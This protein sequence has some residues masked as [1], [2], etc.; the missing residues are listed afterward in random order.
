MNGGV[1]CLYKGKR[2]LF[3]PFILL[4]ISDAKEYNIL[5]C[6]Y[7]S[8]G[9]RNVKCALKGFK[10]TFEELASTCPTYEQITL[11]D[12]ARA[13]HDPDFAKSISQHLVW[14]AMNN[15]PLAN[16]SQGIAGSTPYD[17]LH[18]NG[19]GNLK[20]GLEVVHD[21][22]GVNNTRASEKEKL[23]LLFIAV[24][25]DAKRNSERRVPKWATQ[26][27]VCDLTRITATER[28]ENYFIMNISLPTCRG[29]E[30]MQP[31]LEEWGIV[32]EDLCDTM[33]LLLAYDAWVTCKKLKRWELDNAEAAVTFLME[34]MLRNL[35]R[36][37]KDKDSQ[38]PGSNGYHK[39][40][41]QALWLF[42]FSIRDFGSG[43][44]FTGEHGERFHQQTV[45]RNGVNTHKIPRYFG[46]E[47]ARRDAEYKVI[48]HAFRKYK[49]LCL[50]DNDR[51]L[52]EINSTMKSYLLDGEVTECNYDLLGT[53]TLKIE[54]SRGLYEKRECDLT[55]NDGAKNVLEHNIHEQLKH[56]L[57]SLAAQKKWQGP[58]K[59]TG[60]TELRVESDGGTTIYRCSNSYCD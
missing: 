18:V 40:K 30:I 60:H 11:E 10:A 57:C 49:H 42:I 23:N 15:L 28:K 59:V 17:D 41:F 38:G 3:V 46:E 31:F 25:G 21:L 6:H 37:M 9:N 47:V 35:P 4:V 36:D 1:H 26:F 33:S 19:Q 39:L 53:Y 50:E 7:N 13:L 58:F 27:G 8:C 24:S 29:Q 2:V 45:G 5:C 56:A 51:H 16:I 22:I 14:P 34:S 20:D 54:Q 48:Q 43:A 44:N 32:H 12:V 52:Y 55:W